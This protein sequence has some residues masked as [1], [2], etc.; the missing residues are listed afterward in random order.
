MAFD[1]YIFSSERILYIAEDVNMENTFM[2][3][4]DTIF[5]G[6]I[7]FTIEIAS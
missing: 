4:P 1:L 6:N 5:D 2:E 7:N 3:T